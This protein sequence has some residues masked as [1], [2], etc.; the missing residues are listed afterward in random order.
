MH[1]GL[2]GHYRAAL[3]QPVSMLGGKTP[4]ASVRSKAGREMAAAW[5]K[6]LESESRCGRAPSDPMASYDFGWM[7]TELGITNL[8]R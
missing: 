2:S 5:L 3:D 4:R 6:F 8:R 1:E 7:W